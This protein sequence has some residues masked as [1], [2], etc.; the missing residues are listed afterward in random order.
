MQDAIEK[1]RDFHK[2][3]NRVY[4]ELPTIPDDDYLKLRVD[5]IQ[6]EA[7]EFQEAASV[8]D[9]VG[10]A[11]ALA[12]LLYV[13]FGA[14]GALGIPIEKIFNE[15]HRSNMTKL[16][17]DGTAHYYPSGKVMKPDTFSPPNIVQFL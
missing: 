7:D 17:P 11:D 15:V 8:K 5:L 16:F 1:V 3:F 10:M 13:T 6:E 9:M 12:D 14:A 2:K 4:N